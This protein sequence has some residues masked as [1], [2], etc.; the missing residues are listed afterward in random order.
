MTM[1]QGIAARGRWGALLAVL[2]IVVGIIAVAEPVVAGLAVALL[3]GWVLIFGAIGHV[4]GA[5]GA[6]GL[7]RGIWQALVGIAYFLAGMYFVTH[8]LL[9]LTTLTIVLAI[10]LFVE[11][12][13]ELMLYWQTRT[14]PG[15]GWRLFNTL[16]TALLAVMIWAHWPSS[17]AWAIGTLVG[18]KLLMTG[19]TGLMLAGAARRLSA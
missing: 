17:S 5:F 16:V 3:V 13:F 19:F 18:V 15:S 1:V 4:V 14:L 9:G 7:G 11:A 2:F 12:M 8:P 6:G 10:V